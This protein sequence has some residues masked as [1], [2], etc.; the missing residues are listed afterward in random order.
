MSKRRARAVVDAGQDP[1]VLHDSEHGWYGALGGTTRAWD[2][3]RPPEDFEGESLA[4]VRGADVYF[5]DAR[6]IHRVDAEG[7]RARW[8]LRMSEELVQY[9]PWSDVAVDESRL[10]M[11]SHDIPP[12]LLDVVPETGRATLR[13]ARG[14]SPILVGT[15][16]I[17]REQRSVLALDLSREG[18][19]PR[20]SFPLRA[21]VDRA[22]DLL[23]IEV[24][25]FDRDPAHYPFDAR[26]AQEWLARLG[27][28]AADQLIARVREGDLEQAAPA[29][30]LLAPIETASARAAATELLQRS[31]ALEPTAVRARALA[32]AARSVREVTPGLAAALLANALSWARATREIDASEL[33][34]SACASD[35]QCDLGRA[36][37]E[38][39]AATRD[40]LARGSVDAAPLLALREGLLG[41]A[42]DCRATGDDAARWAVV[43]RALELANEPDWT[44]LAVGS[45]CDALATLRGV[46][47]VIVTDEEIE[48]ESLLVIGQPV[49][50]V[51]PRRDDP[52]WDDA[53]TRRVCS[54]WLLGWHRMPACWLVQEV[55]AVW[56]V[57]DE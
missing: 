11:L 50:A 41:P 1:V 25:D 34:P 16:L 31:L 20:A 26:S 18:P 33:D 17:S 5:A 28:L 43:Q 22:I 53:P 54:E 57:V 46:E 51:A 12:L 10:V 39:I 52:A 55:D 14:S 19:P 30:Q 29:A 4:A 49:R 6:G 40:L 56:R 2:R 7:G 23:T 38:A 27:P 8:S 48:A 35:P 36:T 44:V 37:R 42:P 3:P 13:L 47:R 9:V 24:G 45:P 21:D 32:S 15:T